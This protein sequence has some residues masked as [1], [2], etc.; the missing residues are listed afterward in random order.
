MQKL[1]QK[2]DFAES[3]RSIL[4]SLLF[5]PKSTFVDQN[6]FLTLDHDF[7][8]ENK[9]DRNVGVRLVMQVLWSTYGGYQLFLCKKAGEFLIGPGPESPTSKLYPY[10]QINPEFILKCYLSANQE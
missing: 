8:S 9:M 3:F 2:G 10:W 4:F 7:L 5:G 1:F 6:Q